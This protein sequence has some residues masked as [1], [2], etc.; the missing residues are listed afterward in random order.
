MS[1]EFD[2]RP[3]L[4]AVTQR[5]RWIA[6]AAVLAASAAGLWAATRPQ[7]YSASAT[8]LLR[9]SQSQLTLD[10]RYATR[11]LVDVASRR[12]TLL[13]LARSSAVEEGIPNEPRERLGGGEYAGGDLRKRIRTSAD[14]DVISIT[15]EGP[16][17]EQAQ[18]LANAWAT[19]YVHFINKA[20]SNS[21]EETLRS[22]DEQVRATKE[23]Y[24]EAQLAL[25]QFA[26]QS[27]IDTL[28]ARIESTLSVISQTLEIDQIRH[29]AYLKV[30]QQL[31]LVVRDAEALRREV[32]DGGAVGANTALA[33][34][35]IRARASAGED[36][37]LNLE[38]NP[39][40]SLEQSDVLRTEELDAFITSLR[41]QI[42]ETEEA[43]A[44]LGAALANDQRTQGQGPTLDQPA[45]YFNQ[46]SDLRRQLEAET[47]KRHALVLERDVA[48]EALQAVQRKAMEEEVSAALPEPQVQVASQ[49]ILPSRPAARPVLL[50]SLVGALVGA[51][52]GS[53]AALLLHMLRLPTMATRRQTNIDQRANSASSG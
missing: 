52:L 17:A 25:E 41:Q 48:M 10:E 29:E 16:T 33:A 1:N 14:G 40:V 5:S 49:A 30:A 22:I 2:L 43:A 12:R 28:N 4:R 46:L 45:M 21:G 7:V 32:A 53:F 27:Q 9:S 47:G 24:E 18:E 20:F 35:L 39:P 19:S 44:Q 51:V 11:E 34:L 3:Y 8:V 26:G 42:S 31:E 50:F 15:A 13:S 37:P 6:I 38:L 23:R 36:F